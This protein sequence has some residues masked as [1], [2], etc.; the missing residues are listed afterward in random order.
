VNSNAE[1]SQY[2]RLFADRLVYNSTH[3]KLQSYVS[4]RRY[5][6]ASHSQYF[7]NM[8]AGTIYCIQMPSL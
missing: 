3:D 6:A 7:Y 4:L 5:T 2:E 8:A 1:I